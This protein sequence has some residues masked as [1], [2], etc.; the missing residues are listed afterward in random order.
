MPVLFAPALVSSFFAPDLPRRGVLGVP[1]SPASEEQAAK[2][3]L[4]KGEGLVV[5][6]PIAG[7]TGAKAG[8]QPGDVIVKINERTAKAQGLGEWVRTL[9]SGG[10]VTF[11]VERAGKRLELSSA[12]TERPRD[13]GN[14]R[15]S[16]EYRHVTSHGARMR[17]IVTKPKKAGK[18]P[19]LLFIQGFSP[20]SYDYVLADATGDVSTIDG[21]ILFDMADSG[22]VTMRVEKPGVGDSEGGPFATMDFMTEY[23]IYV[24][25]AEQLMDCP[26]V[27]K[28]NVFIFGHSMGGS[29]GPMVA[30]DTKVKGLI[31]YGTAGRTWFEYLMDTI[32]YQ[33]LVAGQSYEAA[34]DDARSGARLMALAMIEKQSPDAIKKS[35][36]DLAPLVDAY[37]PNGL[38]N[39]K[40]LDFWRQLNDTNFAR[41]WA[42]CGSH[43]LAVRGES[44]FVTYDADHKLIADIVNRANP[45][46]GTFKIEPKSD[47]LFH[48]FATEQESLKNFQRGRFN[49]SFAKTMKDWI[50]QVMSG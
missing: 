26:E 6:K 14:E 35:H 29:F 3:G 43:V 33:G 17:T 10:K 9:P 41:Y 32:R 4:A 13:P 48:E 21:P 23:D 25:A 20:V 49:K 19:G 37:F 50:A 42:K 30:C 46:Y 31:V 47:H 1:F 27:D 22:F 2:S 36:P 7:L 11:T 12:L 38:F 40:T 28:D 45:G 44:D 24:K 15:F 39:G 18:H 34:D 16:V 8:L 5:G